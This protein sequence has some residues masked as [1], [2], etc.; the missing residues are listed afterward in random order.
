VT[1]LSG[2][3]HRY[4]I[5]QVRGTL[6]GTPWGVGGQISG[7]AVTRY[8]SSRFRNRYL[9]SGRPDICRCSHQILCPGLGRYLSRRPQPDIWCLFWGAIWWLMGTSARYLA[10]P[11]PDNLVKAAPTRYLPLKSDQI[12]G[13]IWYVHQISGSLG[14]YLVCERTSDEV[15]PGPL[16]V[17]HHDGSAAHP[18]PPASGSAHGIPANPLTA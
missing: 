1:R 3:A 14:R 17:H 5:F 11:A 15:V 9:V 2:W 10:P 16:H 13:K 12:M 18:G 8:L 7:A 4:G 6:G